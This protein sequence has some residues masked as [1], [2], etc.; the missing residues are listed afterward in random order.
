VVLSLAAILVWAMVRRR[1]PRAARVRQELRGPAVRLLVALLAV[2]L[3]VVV[4]EDVLEREHDEWILQLDQWGHAWGQQMAARPG[5]RAVAALVSAL[6]GTGLAV[7]VA[8]AAAA[9]AR[10]GRARDARVLLVATL[11][12]WALSGALKYVLGVPRPRGS[13]AGFPSGHT[14]V[15][16][17]ACG[18]LAW[19][20]SRGRRPGVRWTLYALAGAA[21]ALSG[22]SRIVLGMHWLSDVVAGLAVGILCVTAVAAAATPR[23]PGLPVTST[24]P[25]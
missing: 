4:A 5:L 12:A 11:G 7:M 3:L 21:A 10:M 17:V 22:W 1:S 25:P 19:L 6:T 16:L 13:A 9:L 24:P 23:G 14:L 18:V 15:T 8:L 20:V 2:V